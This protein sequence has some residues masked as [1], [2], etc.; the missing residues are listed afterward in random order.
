MKIG[1]GNANFITDCHDMTVSDSEMRKRWEQGNYGKP[2]ADYAK[3][4]RKL[5]GRK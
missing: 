2:R 1:H 4:W 5:A 3:A